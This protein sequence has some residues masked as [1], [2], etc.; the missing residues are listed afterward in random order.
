[1]L[2]LRGEKANDNMLEYNNTCDNGNDNGNGL[3]QKLKQLIDNN[4]STPVELYWVYR[5][6]HVYQILPTDWL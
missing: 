2:Y 3:F 5:G 1:M 6:A 4:S